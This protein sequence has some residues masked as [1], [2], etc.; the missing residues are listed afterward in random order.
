MFE[1][2]SDNCGMCEGDNWVGDTGTII[3]FLKVLGKHP[4]C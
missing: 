2:S 1:V 3:D 4:R